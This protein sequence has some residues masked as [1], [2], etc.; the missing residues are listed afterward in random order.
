MTSARFFTFQ[1]NRQ[2]GNS[3]GHPVSRDAEQNQVDVA[4]AAESTIDW[5]QKIV[6][7]VLS[8]P[9]PSTLPTFMSPR[10]V[11]TS[12]V[13]AACAALLFLAAAHAGQDS[14]IP[15]ELADETVTELIQQLDAPE[16]SIRQSATA[17]LIRLGNR[18]VSEL[19]AA[20]STGSLERRNRISTILVKIQ[21]NSFEG[22]LA[23][24]VQTR[25]KSDLARLPCWEQFAEFTEITEASI[26]LFLAMMQ[27]ESRLFTA[28]HEAP[29]N[30]SELLRQRSA[31]L[32]KLERP[33]QQDEAS[34]P[35]ESYVATLLLASD[36]S[37]RL[38]G[39]TSSFLSQLLQVTEFQKAL[40]DTETGELFRR[41][42]GA[43]ILRTGISVDRPLLFAR[44]HRLEEGLTLA[45]R[46]VRAKTR[47]S[48]TWYAIALLSE[49]GT[50]DDLQLIETKLND[51]VVHYPPRTTDPDEYQVQ[52]RDAALAA[53]L[54]L[55]GIYPGRYGFPDPE[56]NAPTFS[57]L[58]T[59][60]RSPEIRE[61]AHARYRATFL[62]P[63]AV[64]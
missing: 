8:H 37:I 46:V 7:L 11:I 49:M 33:G 1:S 55:R 53:A 20:L 63:D 27:A 13:K 6:L 31:D 36:E 22:L 45:R 2:P 21:R 54:R 42:T 4:D 10:F 15:E 41:I 32:M 56:D 40:Y 29:E 16:F 9:G 25:D 62:N 19:K 18:A 24:A 14:S 12:F 64:P 38:T 44:A 57:H 47:P 59:G 51:T 34:F 60:F 5:R 17:T 61:A 23:K 35:V 58:T 39:A 28:R 30:V 3:R 26:G 43:W 48:T 52:T 50:V